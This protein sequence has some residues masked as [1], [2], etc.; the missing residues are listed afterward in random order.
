[1]K[2]FGKLLMR[3]ALQ[4]RTYYVLSWLAVLG[5]AAGVLYNAWIHFD[6]HSESTKPGSKR[7]DV[8]DGHCMIDFGGQWLMGRMLYEGHGRRLY[9]RSQ[10][11]AVLQVSY[12]EEDQAPDAEKSDAENLMDWL[13]GLDAPEGAGEPEH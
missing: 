6:D 8:N 9:L 11:R 3:W 10:Q 5:I 2:P 7:R 13:M 4:S 1:M 12:P